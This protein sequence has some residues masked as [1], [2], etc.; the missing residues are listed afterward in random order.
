MKISSIAA[1][2]LLSC[3]AAAPLESRTTLQTDQLAAQGLTNLK[4]YVK[5]NGYPN[6][7]CT[8]DNVSVRKEW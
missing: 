3:A 8:I 6:K 7:K 2:T 4:A 1:A 5:K